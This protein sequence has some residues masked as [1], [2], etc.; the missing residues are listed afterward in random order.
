VPPPDTE[1]RLNV[2]EATYDDLRRL[3][4]SVTQTGRLLDYRNSLGGFRSLDQLDDIVG[5][6]RELILEL[7]GKLTI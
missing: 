4:L 7:K 5:F 6:P 2:N 3:R 1:G